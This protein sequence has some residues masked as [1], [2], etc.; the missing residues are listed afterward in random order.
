[1]SKIRLPMVAASSFLTFVCTTAIFQLQ[2]VQAVE[3]PTT[4]ISI[5]KAPYSFGGMLPTAMTI[6]QLSR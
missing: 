6:L 1:M 2:I 5:D 3:I 4:A